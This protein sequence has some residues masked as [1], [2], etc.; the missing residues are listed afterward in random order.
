MNYLEESAKTENQDWAAI[1]ARL[2]NEQVVQLLHGAMGLNTESGEIMDTLKK[3][4]IYGSELNIT[5]LKEEIG[6]IAW[7]FAL[8]CRALGMT[9]EE[10]F[11][12]NIAKLAKRYPNKFSKEAAENRN[13]VNELSHY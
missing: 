6:D 1:A 8:I 4:L 9:I 10:V 3:N 13:V 7:Y 5:N 12:K 11:E 2:N